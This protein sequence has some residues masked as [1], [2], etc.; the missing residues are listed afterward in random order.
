MGHKRRH[1]DR[2]LN[3]G[4]LEAWEDETLSEK[5]A[6]NN[7][8]IRCNRKEVRWGGEWIEYSQV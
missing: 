4:E 7:K 6:F 1:L 8:Q 3:T 2:D 5:H